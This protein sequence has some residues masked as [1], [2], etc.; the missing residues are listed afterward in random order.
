[1]LL[2]HLLSMAFYL[3]LLH[4]LRPL[5]MLR[6]LQLLRLLRPFYLS[7]SPYLHISIS[8]YFYISMVSIAY[9]HRLL[10]LAFFSNASMLHA[11]YSLSSPAPAHSCA[12]RRYL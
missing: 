11:R 4:L 12:R 7:I 9:T 8:P 10:L 1:M 2:L 6:V 5:R 3:N